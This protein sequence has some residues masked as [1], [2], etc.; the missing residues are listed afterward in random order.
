MHNDTNM[1]PIILIILS[2]TV[3]FAQEWK[4]YVQAQKELAKTQA[5]L[6]TDFYNKWY[7]HLG[8]LD[9]KPLNPII[10]PK[11]SQ[12]IERNEIEQVN[13]FMRRIGEMGSM[14][15]GQKREFV[16][17]FFKNGAAIY[18]KRKGK[19]PPIDGAVVQ[20]KADVTAG[21]PV[22]KEKKKI[23]AT[24]ADGTLVGQ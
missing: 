8:K 24:L 6:M 15:E 17:H 13:Y 23:T 14:D 4:P 5:D 11:Q 7:V 10:D 12:M 20:A 9:L 2:L 21:E 22:K 18:E 16:D 1:K 19:M 3:S